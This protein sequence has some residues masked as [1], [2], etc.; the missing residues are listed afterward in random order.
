MITEKL[1]AGT[2]RII[3]TPM[4]MTRGPVIPTGE[5][6]IGR[7]KMLRTVVATENTVP[8]STEDDIKTILSTV[9]L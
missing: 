2:T 1:M 5:R 4:R 3:L 7:G 8:V 9:K 6:M